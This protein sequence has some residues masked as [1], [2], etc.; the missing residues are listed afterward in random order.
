M[1]KYLMG[2]TR[3]FEAANEGK[4]GGD[5]AAAKAA[6]E[7]A[8]A[9][10]DAKAAEDTAKDEAAAAA[11]AAAAKPGDLDAKKLAEEKAELLREVMDK[12]SKLS[13]TA[14][15]LADAKKALEAYG[16]I[17][18]AKV[19]ALIKAEQDAEKASLEAKGDFERVKAMMAEE[20]AKE[21]KILEDQLAAE[22]AERQKDRS[23][24]DE[25]TIGNAFGNS[26]Y[27]KEDLILS[28]EKA[29]TIYGG[30]FEMKD[31]RVVAYD[32][33]ASAANRTML[34]NSA[35]DPLAFN[36]ALERI[37]EADPDKKTMLKSKMKPGSSSNSAQPTDQ[38]QKAKAEDG[39]FGRSRIAASLKNL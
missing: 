31:G 6:A 23:L 37:I 34:V 12:K 29:R 20:H 18:P 38:Q 2:T 15:D 17:D 25:L 28:P 35:G 11:A 36:E 14:K 24:I 7:A 10:A 22:R 4:P 19:Q 9:A 21:R 5:D 39:L 16:G 33:P 13:A 30:H 32:K 1:K 3:M 27:I 26:T 8:K